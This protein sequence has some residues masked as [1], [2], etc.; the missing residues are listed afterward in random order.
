MPNRASDTCKRPTELSSGFVSKRLLILCLFG[1]SVK[2][3]DEMQAI[4][5]KFPMQGKMSVIGILLD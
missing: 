4:T 1:V 2:I 3:T 5:L